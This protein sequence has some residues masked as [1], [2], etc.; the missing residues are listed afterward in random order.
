MSCIFKK[1]LEKMA[2]FFEK[3]WSLYIKMVYWKLY[4]NYIAK[5]KIS[6]IGIGV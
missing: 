2:I 3:I 1:L 4:V 6:D 5:N